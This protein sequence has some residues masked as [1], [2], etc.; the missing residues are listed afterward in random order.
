MEF[1]GYLSS[2]CLGLCAV[3]AAIVAIKNKKCSYP[4]GFLGLWW[5]GEILGLIY[6]S[7]LLDKPLIMNYTVNVIATSLLIYY[8]KAYDDK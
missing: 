3:P 4:W 8:N 7:F 6:V 2:I 1:V 5:A